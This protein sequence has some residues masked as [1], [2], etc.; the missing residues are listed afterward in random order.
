M[1][2]K[3]L[4]V[5]NSSYGKYGNIV[6]THLDK[7][8]GKLNINQINEELI[9]FIFKNVYKTTIILQVH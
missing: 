6:S 2:V 3:K 8:F 1:K 5:K 7:N 9:F 4:S